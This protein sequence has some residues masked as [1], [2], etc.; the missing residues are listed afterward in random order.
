MK[1]QNEKK[2]RHPQT[3]QYAQSHNKNRSN[4][5]LKKNILNEG[6]RMRKISQH[7]TN[8]TNESKMTKKEVLCMRNSID[9]PIR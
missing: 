3:T 7:F 2:A 6:E 9:L 4:Q 1:K 5:R 8:P